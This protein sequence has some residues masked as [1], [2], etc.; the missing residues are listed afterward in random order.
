MTILDLYPNVEVQLPKYTFDWIPQAYKPRCRAY[1]FASNTNTKGDMVFI[2]SRWSYCQLTT[3][4]TPSEQC[5][6]KPATGRPCVLAL[7]D[8]GTVP[9]ITCDCSPV[10]ELFMRRRYF[11]LC[12]PASSRTMLTFEN[13]V[14]CS[15]R[16]CSTIAFCRR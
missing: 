4:C 15:N 8:S 3:F 5:C 6:L 11:D 13:N 2:I 7:V 10:A 9:A 14:S 12:V 1:M 16:Y